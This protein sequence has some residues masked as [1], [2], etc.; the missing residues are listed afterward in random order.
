MPAKQKKLPKSAGPLQAAPD[1]SGKPSPKDTKRAGS[2]VVGLSCI[3]V[4]LSII[5]A[6]KV[7]TP[8][9]LTLPIFPFF[10]SALRR[11]R[12]REAVD[13]T[14]RWAATIF[15]CSVLAGGFVPGRAERS[16][17]F[18]SRSADAFEE[19]IGSVEGAPPADFGY[20]LGGGLIFLAAALPSGGALGFIIGSIALAS[21]G[22]GAAYAFRHGDN[23]FHIVLIALPPWQWSLFIG[24][25]FLLV[26]VVLVVNRFYPSG[27]SKRAEDVRFYAY[28]GAGFYVLSFILR[29]ATAGL[30][31]TITER[32]TVF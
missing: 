15:I 11:Q 32:W 10:L 9:L 4:L 13:L 17:L 14:M 31:K 8:L 3:S 20:L 27:E 23:I 26:P 22:Y 12:R 24:C 29:L 6:F 16:F 2:F 30:W 1:S 28:V 19:W 21:S 5:I 18:A 25:L 7:L